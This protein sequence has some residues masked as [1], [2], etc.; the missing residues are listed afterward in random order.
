[1][2]SRG[3]PRLVRMLLKCREGHSHPCRTSQQVQREKAQQRRGRS[4]ADAGKS[5]L[6]REYESSSGIQLDG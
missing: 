6:Q 2:G 4:M 3:V 5:A 1:V